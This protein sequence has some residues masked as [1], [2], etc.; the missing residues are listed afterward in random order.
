MNY[1]NK[2]AWA[3]PGA[4]QFGN[5]P[6]ADGSVRGFPTYN[7]DASLFKIFKLHERL[8]MRFD[9]EFGNIFNRTDFCSPDA[10][11]SDATFGTVNTQCNQAR[12]IQFGLRFDY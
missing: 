11:F 10:N 9:A 8:S 2:T 7:E 6:R 4:D 5:A 12:S 1:F 3:D